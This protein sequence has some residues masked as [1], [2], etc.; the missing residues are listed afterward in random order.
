LLQDFPNRSAVAWVLQGLRQGFHS[1]FLGLP[2]GIESPNL[3]SA[4]ERPEELD[5]IMVSNQAEGIVAGPFERKPVEDMMVSPLGVIPKPH[6]PNKFR[7][8]QHLSHPP[9]NSV[10]DRIPPESRAVALSTIADLTTFALHSPGMWWGGFDI[11]WMYYTFPLRPLCQATQGVRWRWMLPD[12]TWVLRYFFFRVLSFGLA[13]GPRIANA[14]ADL[15]DW[16]FQSRGIS[17]SLN[18][19]DDFRIGGRTRPLAEA[20]WRQAL[21]ILDFIRW[22]R[23]PDKDIPVTQVI[24]WVGYITDTVQQTV[25]LERETLERHAAAFRVA[26]AA[27]A[28]SRKQLQSLAGQL[29]WVCRVAPQLRVFAELIFQRLR[30][31]R[32]EWLRLHGVLRDTFSYLAT[33]LPTVGPARFGGESAPVFRLQFHQSD[34]SLTGG[35]AVHGRSAIAVSW[36]PALDVD[37]AGHIFVRELLMIFISVATFVADFPQDREV[38]IETDNQNCVTVWERGATR[39]LVASQVLRAFVAFL[40]QHR[41]RLSLGYIPSKDNYAADLLSRGNF[42]QFRFEFPNIVARPA[43]LPPIPGWGIYAVDRVSAVAG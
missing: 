3:S 7:A 6:Q 5:K 40:V 43:V 24:F 31:S 27:Y 16:V 20:A 36:T 25:T 30:E 19:F 15:L 8:I 9:G 34:A 32:L 17:V 39:S 11:K 29:L 13:S 42:D 4:F 26:S 18:I 1:G 12:G 38:A 41:L 21:R 28:H 33:V 37:A 22:P 10:N 23:N 14:F 35:G 2:S